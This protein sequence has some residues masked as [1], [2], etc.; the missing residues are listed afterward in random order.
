MDYFD[1]TVKLTG[2][3]EYGRIILG[4]LQKELSLERIFSFSTEIIFSSVIVLF[5]I[6]SNALLVK[7]V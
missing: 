7:E 1:K 6:I 5:S 4:V 2:S 3:I